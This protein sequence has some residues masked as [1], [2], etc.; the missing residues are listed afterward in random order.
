MPTPE[1]NTRKIISRLQA[2]GWVNV[3]GTRHDKFE[4]SDWPDALVVVPRH[5]QQSPGVARS[6]AKLAGWI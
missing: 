5:K 6:I 3:G 2:E 4:H 1:T